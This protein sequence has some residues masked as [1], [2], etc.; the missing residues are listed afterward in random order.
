M[1]SF[2][3][4]PGQMRRRPP[5]S[6]IDRVI[7]H[8]H[9]PMVQRVTLYHRVQ[10]LDWLGVNSDGVVA[11]DCAES[12][13]RNACAA[14]VQIARERIAAWQRHCARRSPPRLLRPRARR[15]RVAR[16]TAAKATADPDGPAPRAPLAH[17]TREAL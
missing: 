7:E 6:F 4:P 13:R 17:D 14:R 5:R 2:R 1:A 15:H 9:G 8:V 16:R 3:L 12:I 10:W 11:T